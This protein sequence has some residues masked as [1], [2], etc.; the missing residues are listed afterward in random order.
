MDPALMG[1]ALEPERVTFDEKMAVRKVIEEANN[2]FTYVVANCFAGNFIGKLSQFERFTPP[3]DKVFL[4][5]DGNVKELIQKWETLSG[6][7]LQKINISIDDFLASMKELD[8]A[9]LDL[10]G[11]VG[12]GHFYYIFYEGCLTNFEIGGEEASQLYP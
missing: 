2:P 9:E 11:Q 4:Y 3:K 5:G 6:R 1:H 7:K 10:A 8:F 12:L